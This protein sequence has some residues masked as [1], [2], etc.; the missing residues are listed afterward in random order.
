MSAVA[1]HPALPGHLPYAAFF[2]GSLSTCIVYDE[3]GL[4]HEVRQSEVGEQRDPLTPVFGRLRTT[5][6]SSR[7]QSPPSP[8][9]HWMTSMPR[10]PPNTSKHTAGQFAVGVRSLRAMCQHPGSSRQNTCVEQRR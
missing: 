3:E 7:G 1:D 6:I 2:S 10:D 5:P 8:V 9:E 4:A